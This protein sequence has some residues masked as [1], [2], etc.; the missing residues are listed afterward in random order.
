[1]ALM[2]KCY[3]EIAPLFPNR[4]CALVREQQDL[5]LILADD[6]VPLSPP[7]YLKICRSE[8]CVQFITFSGQ[9]IEIDG[10]A[11]DVLTDANGH[12]LLAGQK[13]VWTSA[14]PEVVGKRYRVQGKILGAGS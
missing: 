12:V 3:S 13:L 8:G 9:Q 1:M 11:Y 5:R 7:V 6:G 14:R 10:E 2:Q 4:L